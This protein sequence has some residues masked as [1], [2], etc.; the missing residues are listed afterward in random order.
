M[1]Y[2]IYF[3]ELESC[4]FYVWVM[5]TVCHN[6]IEIKYIDWNFHK[7]LL[8]EMGCIHSHNCGW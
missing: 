6:K 3:D 7:S 2:N 8:L 4:T 5:S 1:L